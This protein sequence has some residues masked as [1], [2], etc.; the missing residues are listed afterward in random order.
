[1]LIKICYF[2]DYSTV[3]CIAGYTETSGKLMDNSLFG[4]SLKASRRGLIE[5]SSWLL[6]GDPV[7]LRIG[8]LEKIPTFAG[9]KSRTF[10]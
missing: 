4:R 10:Q 3:L 5:S 6:P 1:M 9:S 2:L 7:K 8:V